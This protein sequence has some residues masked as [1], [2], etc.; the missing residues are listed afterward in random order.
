MRQL[1]NE[2]CVAEFFGGGSFWCSADVEMKKVCIAMFLVL[3][4]WAE[5]VVGRLSPCLVKEC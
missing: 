1:F 3:T 5:F 4:Q 2:D